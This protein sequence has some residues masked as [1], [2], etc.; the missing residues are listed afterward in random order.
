M[1]TFKFPNMSCTDSRLSL[2][3][4]PKLHFP[5]FDGDHLKLWQS[6]CESYFEMYS[7]DP[8]VWVCVVTIHFDSVAARWLQSVNYH[9]LTVYWKELCGWILD[10][11]GRDQ[12]E[13]LIW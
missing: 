13:A 6:R 8:G 7:V 9:I 12:H 11:F 1:D 5:K 4:L 3:Q 10:R 2:G